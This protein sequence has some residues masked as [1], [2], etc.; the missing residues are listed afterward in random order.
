[1]KSHYYLNLLCDIIAFPITYL[2][3]GES[4]KNGN[5]AQAKKEPD[6]SRPCTPF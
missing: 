5:V 4:E 3:S 2:M 6:Y 1:M